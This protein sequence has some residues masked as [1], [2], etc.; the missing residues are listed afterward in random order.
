MDSIHKISHQRVIR[1]SSEYDRFQRIDTAPYDTPNIDKPFVSTAVPKRFLTFI[2]DKMSGAMLGLKHLFQDTQIPS[3]DSIPL[4]QSL[5]LPAFPQEKLN[6][7]SASI[8]Q[9]VSKPEFQ[10]RY[11]TGSERHTEVKKSSLMNVVDFYKDI[12]TEKLRE[13]MKREKSNVIPQ[14]VDCQRRPVP[15]YSNKNTANEGTRRKQGKDQINEHGKRSLR[16]ILH[17]KDK[18]SRGNKHVSFVPQLQR[19]SSSVIKYNSSDDEDNLYMQDHPHKK[20]FIDE[21]IILKN[22]PAIQLSFIK[23]KKLKPNP[24]NQKKIIQK[25]TK[26][27]SCLDQKNYKKEYI[28]EFEK[29]Y[30]SFGNDN[31]INDSKVETDSDDSSLLHNSFDTSNFQAIKSLGNKRNPRNRLESPSEKEDHALS[32]SPQKVESP[33]VPIAEEKE[34]NYIDHELPEVKIQKLEEKE[35]KINIESSKKPEETKSQDSFETIKSSIFQN[36]SQPKEIKEVKSDTNETPR[37]KGSLI[38]LIM[39]EPTQEVSSKSLFGGGLFNNSQNMTLEKPKEE[40][41]LPISTLSGESKLGSENISET[42]KTISPFAN[43]SSSLFGKK[44]E[45]SVS[46]NPFLPDKKEETVSEGPI[47]G[48]TTSKIDSEVLKNPV[49]ANVI[50]TSSSP[51]ENNNP[52]LNFTAQRQNSINFADLIS[53]PKK[54]ESTIITDPIKPVENNSNVPTINS[55]VNDDKPKGILELFNTHSKAPGQESGLLK[56]TLTPTSNALWLS[57]TNENPSLFT[58]SSNL[59][60]TTLFSQPPPQSSPFGQLFSQNNETST[61]GFGNNNSNSIL[62]G[63]NS[64]LGNNNL[65]SNSLFGGNMGGELSNQNGGMGLFGGNNSGSNNFQSFAFGSNNNT[66]SNNPFLSQGAFGDSSSSAFGSNL[67]QGSFNM[68]SGQKKK[69]QKER[70]F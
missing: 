55:V 52:F 32:V 50:N 40:Q 6:N 38:S 29:K 46:S 47:L 48:K 57:N 54:A 12:S 3:I 68:G 4:S 17:Q 2:K 43:N 65:S 16:S 5:K 61:G 37:Q 60:Q 1:G 7:L 31:L 56:R 33:E 64:M 45:Q 70:A 15:L 44:S 24:F 13:S 69:N 19:S 51:A 66:N 41:K 28:G 67:S 20:I 18:V 8:Q 11:S 14:G 21:K 25:A 58:S 22:E 23:A 49:F 26:A 39:Q 10:N 30:S 36:I 63:G 53:G 9:T 27:K 59:Q 62:G 35:L 42:S 34:E